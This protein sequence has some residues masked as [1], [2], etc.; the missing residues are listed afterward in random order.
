[1]V[2]SYGCFGLTNYKQ[3]N[4]LKKHMKWART[5]SRHQTA[6]HVSTAVL[7]EEFSLLAESRSDTELFTSEAAVTI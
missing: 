4:L 5:A 7:A 2:Y 6:R 3:T 1:M